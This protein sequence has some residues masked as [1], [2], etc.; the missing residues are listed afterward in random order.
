MQN[1]KRG[2]Q[3]QFPNGIRKADIAL[4][5]VCVLAA[6]LTGVFLILYRREGDVVRVSCDGEQLA[7]FTLAATEMQ[8]R[9]YYL[10]WAED[11]QMTVS[12]CGNAPVI[13]DEGA[14]NLF[15]VT[16]G[17][18]RMEAADCRDQICV[19]HR[20]VSAVGESI[21]CLPHKLVV[22]I[23]TAETHLRGTGKE[24]TGQGN[25]GDRKDNSL[26]STEEALDRVVE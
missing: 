23:T 14:F 4:V 20:A 24:Q 18:V 8:G 5:V 9:Q 21:I 10:V 22:E 6:V 26:D 11:G 19:R 17:V 15:S 1:R 2:Q 16:D 3:G 25:L 12:N 7:V 13:P